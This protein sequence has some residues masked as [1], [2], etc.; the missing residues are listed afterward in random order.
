[1]LLIEIG[2]G[3]NAGYIKEFYNGDEMKAIRA[4]DG[5]IYVA[6]EKELALFK[7][8]Y[9]SEFATTPHRCHNALTPVNDTKCDIEKMREYMK[10]NVSY[11][12]W[13]DIEKQTFIT[14]KDMTRSNYAEIEEG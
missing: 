7:K 14:Y 12:K 3:C 5:I 13:Y 4:L 1:M 9:P 6:N 11:A 10:N 2:T 8:E